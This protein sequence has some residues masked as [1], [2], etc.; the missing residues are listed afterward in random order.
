MNL[1][2]FKILFFLFSIHYLANAQPKIF[3][4]DNFRTGFVVNNFLN[5]DSFPK[6]NPLILNELTIG[7]K[8]LGSKYWQSVYNYPDVA[9]SIFVG[10]L[11]NEKQF[12]YIYA[13]V[14]SLTF[15]L[16]TYSKSNILASLGWGLA[17]ITKPYDS[18][19]N[20]H[21]ILLGSKINHFAKIS[22]TYKY[23]FPKNF[24]LQVS[25]A[26]LH[27][28]NGHFQ[29]PNGGMNF[30]SIS[31]GAKKYFI[32]D[33]ITSLPPK[34]PLDKKNHINLSLG[35]G[36]H[37]FAGTLKPVGTP[38][39]KVYTSA[40][41]ITKNYNYWGKYYIGI[42]GKYYKAFN[43]YIKKQNLYSK[44]IATKSSIFTFFI[45]NEFKFGHFGIFAWGG[46]NFYTP[47]VK[48]FVYKN[49]TMYNINY[50]YELYISSKLGMKY[51]I[52]NPETSKF[53]IFIAAAIK[54]N[55][56]NAD[57]TEISSGI[58]F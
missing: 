3:I 26:Y 34:N 45:G 15:N 24:S 18:T 10:D 56:G 25:G 50:F 6:S 51:Y 49:E 16:K 11:G 30:A 1:R 48:N 12:G 28:S 13:L 14:P 42:S 23:N 4:E 53:N 41:F 55:F 39:Y 2:F 40:I 27:A 32:F 21:N 35:I 57:F 36:L 9:V 19:S 20:P 31:I 54:A 43:Y 17:Y 47:F 8:T 58:V 37:E 5:Y 44:N 29:V 38:K 46:L 33:K 52:L 22:I 7:H